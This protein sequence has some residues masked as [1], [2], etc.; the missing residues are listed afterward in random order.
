MLADPLTKMMRAD[1][2]LSVLDS[3]RWNY[4]QPAA[5]KLEKLKKQE[6]RKSKK[7][8]AEDCDEDATGEA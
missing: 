4:A 2:L 5:G 7:E 6:Y 8:S 1:Y 3:N